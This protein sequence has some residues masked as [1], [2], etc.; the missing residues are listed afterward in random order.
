MTTETLLTDDHPLRFKII[1]PVYEVLTVNECKGHPP[2]HVV[3][4]GV[5]W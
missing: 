4:S 3:R 1:R 5:D 2:L